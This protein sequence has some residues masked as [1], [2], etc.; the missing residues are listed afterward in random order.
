LQRPY[1]EQVGSNKLPYCVRQEAYNHL[2]LVSL[3]LRLVVAGDNCY[4]TIDYV[5]VAVLQHPVPPPYRE[6]LWPVSWLTTCYMH[7]KA[8]KLEEALDMP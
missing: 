1:I 6:Q 8:K 7:S 2:R 4:L 5:Q 3:R